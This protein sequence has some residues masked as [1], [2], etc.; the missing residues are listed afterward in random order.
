MSTDTKTEV[1]YFSKSDHNIFKL[2]FSVHC[3][4][5]KE[6][7]TSLIVNDLISLLC[8]PLL[9][10]KDKDQNS[11]CWQTVKESWT[12]YGNQ[13]SNQQYSV[14]LQSTSFM[15][16]FLGSYKFSYLNPLPTLPL[17]NITSKLMLR[18]TKMSKNNMNSFLKKTSKINCHVWIEKSIYYMDVMSWC[19]L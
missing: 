19:T 3:Q 12:A 18:K 15:P 17:F 11:I 1:C 8:L 16:R 9:L 5:Q 6:K 13:A 4:N 2:V 10:T 7:K 14:S